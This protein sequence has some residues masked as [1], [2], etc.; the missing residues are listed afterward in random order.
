MPPLP[1]RRLAAIER[2]GFGA[3]TKVFITYPYVWWPVD[4]PFIYVVFPAG[5]SILSD[6]AF[7]ALTAQRA[8]EVRNLASMHAGR[9]PVL[10]LDYG[11]P[12]AQLIES[13]PVDNIRSALHTLLVAA[14]GA[15]DVPQPSG[16]VVSGWNADQFAMGAYSFIPV[17]AGDKVEDHA[18]ASPLD[19]VELSKPLWKGRLGFAGEHTELD[20]WA[21]AHGA[22]MSGE[23]EA[24]RVLRVL[25]LDKLG[26]YDLN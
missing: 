6:G 13:Q 2:L 4:A 10:C 3:F 18:H 8:V 9:A 22:M 17:A 26:G 16:C 14:L 7:A 11:P 23:R 24:S 25:D 19:F 1:P 5:D 12:A 21:S 20:C 15:K